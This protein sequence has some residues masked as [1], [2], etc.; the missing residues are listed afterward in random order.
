MCFTS[1]RGVELQRQEAMTYP[2][3]LPGAEVYTTTAC[4]S[5][6]LQRAKPAHFGMCPKTK[7]RQ[8]KALCGKGL[9][10]R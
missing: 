3:L 2:A 6:V 4:R 7:G 1:L 8:A 9:E 5:F 10:T